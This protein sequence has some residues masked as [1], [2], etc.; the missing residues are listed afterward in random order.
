MCDV[1]EDHPQ[2][3]EARK[4]LWDL[5]DETP[6]LVWQL[7][8]KRIENAESMVPWGDNWP[9]NVWLGTSTENQTY[10]D[11]RLQVLYTLPAK[12][13]FISAEPL[14]G[15]IDL[16]RWMPQGNARW[17]CGGCHRFF[18]GEWQETC[19]ACG[20]VGYWSGSHAGNSH[21][22]GQPLGWIVA[23]R[24]ERTWCAP[25]RTGVASFPS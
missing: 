14:L 21:P 2:V 16:A 11:K 4:S 9:S 13:R 17:Q 7:L 19:P 18:S 24:R 23:G 5:I 15:P 6:W 20:R 25:M 1:F 10:A 22:G 8:T 12:V 3:T